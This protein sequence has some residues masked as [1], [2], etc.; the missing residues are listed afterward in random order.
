MTK[1][2]RCAF[3]F[4]VGMA[5]CAHLYIP[6]LRAQGYPSKP[7]HI[8]VGFAPGGNGDLSARTVGQKLS[9]ALGQPVVVD[10]RPGAGGAI[11]TEL[12]AK[13]PADGYA[14]LLMSNSDTIQPALRSKLPYDLERDFAPV[15]VAVVGTA[16]L[17][18]HPSVPAR[19]AKELIALARSQPGKLNYGTS[20]IGS[21]S[22][23]MAELFSM[24]GNV[25]LVH[26]PYKGGAEFVI[27]IVSGQ[28]EAGF[29]SVAAAIPLMDGH[30]LRAIAVTSAKRSASLPAIPTLN[31][32]G[33]QGYDQ[34]TWYGI[35]AP[36][37]TARE[38]VARLNA[39]IVKGVN[40]PEVKA[41][42][43]KQG[44]DVQTGT[45]E[46]FSALIRSEIALNAKLIKLSGA[47]TD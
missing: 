46:Q 15:S 3:Q 13:S 5:V 34:A 4:F 9:E 23:L 35:V 18:V 30:K 40:T 39:I 37:G 33:L 1:A 6:D 44:L 26:V 19:N 16:V 36:A 22:H 28:V 7:I 47:K 38:I 43:M 25:K 27:A 42:F 32:S 21:S 8:V 17:T 29:P 2:T 24:M 11:A 41:A 20:G 12:A 14:L 10:N 45:P 31:E